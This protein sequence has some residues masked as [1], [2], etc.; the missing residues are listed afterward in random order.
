MAPLQDRDGLSNRAKGYIYGNDILMGLAFVVV[1]A[2]FYCRM[3]LGSKRGLWWDDLFIALALIFAVGFGA[4]VNVAM[5]HYG[6]DRHIWSIPADVLTTSAKAYIATKIL[7]VVS[8]TF[9]R[10]ALLLFYLW[11][12]KDLAEKPIRRVIYGVMGLNFALCLVGVFVSVFQCWPVRAAWTLDM[13]GDAHCLN[14]GVSITTVG[15]LL[16]TVDFIVNVLPLPIVARLNVVFKQRMAA[17]V[18]LS[19]GTI[20]TA[21][22]IVREVYVYRAFI[23]TN[24]ITW[25][26]LPLWICAD[27]EIYVGLVCI[28]EV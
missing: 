1:A 16:T 4:T 2:R 7:F 3:R 18:L 21:A 20:A 15:A 14:E 28:S 8:S 25:G 19:L 10:T 24:D 13:R 6:W 9:V 12:I 5:A 26:A 22:G 27:V 23:G 17:T 11:L